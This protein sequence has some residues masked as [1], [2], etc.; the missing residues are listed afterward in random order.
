[1]DTLTTPQLLGQVHMLTQFAADLRAI[2]ER[3]YIPEVAELLARIEMQAGAT[4]AHLARMNAAH[5]TIA[6]VVP[7]D[8]T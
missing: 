6:A 3:R 8:D 2:L 5:D 7:S 1:M 4:H